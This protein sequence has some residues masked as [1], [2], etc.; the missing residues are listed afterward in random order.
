MNRALLLLLP[1]MACIAPVEIEASRAWEDHYPV[2]WA[3]PPDMLSSLGQ[4]PRMRVLLMQPTQTEL[5]ASLQRVQSAVRLRTQAGL[6]LPISISVRQLNDFAFSQYE[7]TVSTT[8]PLSPG[9][10]EL[11]VPAEVAAELQGPRLGFTFADGFFGDRFNLASD[12]LMVEDIAICEY[13][14]P[15]GMRHTVNLVFSE[16]VALRAGA[17]LDAALQLT[18]TA[19]GA[20]MACN[21]LVDIDGHAVDATQPHQGWS[22]DCPA[23]SEPFA[24]NLSTDLLTASGL[25]LGRYGY[26]ARGFSARYARVSGPQNTNCITVRPLTDE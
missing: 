3:D 22:L 5:A 23:P 15:S 1:C 2:F 21:G 20:P 10:Y 8:A 6:E 18:E 9:W 14:T 4:A 11:G 25:A 19:T 24:L 13:S 26:T 12:P 16:P 7:L 17:Q